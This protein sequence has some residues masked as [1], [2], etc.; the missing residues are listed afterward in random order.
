ML[1]GCENCGV[2]FVVEGSD[3][4]EQTNNEEKIWLICPNCKEKYLL[5]V[6]NDKIRE[7]QCKVREEFRKD[8]VNISILDEYRTKIREE[9]IKLREKYE[10]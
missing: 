5:Y 1:V 3:K 2:C 6:I 9:Q 7:L 8:V 10:R 4:Y